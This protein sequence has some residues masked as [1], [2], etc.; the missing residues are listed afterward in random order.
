M[1][2]RKK[3]IEIY[4]SKRNPPERIIRRI[5]SWNEEATISENGKLLK[6]PYSSVH[7]FAR[8]FGLKYKQAKM[9]RVPK[10]PPI[11]RAFRDVAKIIALRKDGMTF[12]EIGERYSVTRQRIEQ[13][14]RLHGNN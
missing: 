5:M 4:I 8:R 6:S 9:G 10:Y 12:R 14:V 1:I 11:S 3:A 2:P 7:M 13:I